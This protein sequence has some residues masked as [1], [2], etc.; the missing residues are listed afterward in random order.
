MEYVLY[1]SN[2][3][4]VGR[5]WSLRY[6]FRLPLWQDLGPTN[7]Y[8]FDAN[9][10]V[11]D[12]IGYDRGEVYSTAFS[13]EPRLNVQYQ[14]TPVSVIK[15]SYARTTQFLQLLSNSAS[16]FTSLE[17]WAPAGPNI[18]PQTADQVA[19]G[20]FREI[21]KRKLT[22]SVEGYYK[23]FHN[24]LDYRDHA[25]LLFNPLIEG[26]LRFGKGYSYGIELMLRKTSGN[27]TGWIGYTYSRAM[28]QTPEVNNG[29]VYPASYDRP[30]DICVN[31]CWDD[32]KH[33]LLSANWIFMTGGT[34][35]AP[36]GFY[37]LN[38]YSIPIY[39]ERNNSRLP[40]YHRLDLSAT[41]NF[42]K[43][44]NRF[45]HSLAVTIY[46]VYARL[47]PFSMNFNKMMNDQGEFV[48]PSNLNGAYEL[49]PTSISVAGM[50]P[51]VN[52]KFRF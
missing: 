27:L 15:G 19:L 46:N 38:G 48:V 14:I 33:W 22:F 49:I 35:T 34:I 16:P 29:D 13:P 9:H 26:E 32:K 12:T 20:F 52:Y 40:D 21:A 36:V 10:H 42:S 41:C 31:L 44:G 18:A 28:V 1:M 23:W 51:S 17:V 30:H 37:Y 8:Y 11:I 45:R 3:Q 6:G 47:N 50:I 4:Q 7:V 2:E 24:R 43:P 5:K 25:N 39:G